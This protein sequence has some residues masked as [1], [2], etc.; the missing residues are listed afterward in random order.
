MVGGGKICT[1]WV[2]VVPDHYLS[3]DL[4]LGCD[5]LGKAPLTWNHRD[6]TLIWEDEL[7]PIH[8]IKPK[9]RVERITVIPAPSQKV[10]Q[11]RVRQKFDL[12]PFK[13]KFIPMK[14]EEQPGTTLIVHPNSNMK[15]VPPAHP[16]THTHTREN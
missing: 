4:L 15:A 16:H 8:F 2:P 1:R 3:S 9:G 10:N 14:I 13:T 5:I 6:Q 12:P 11:L 7:Y